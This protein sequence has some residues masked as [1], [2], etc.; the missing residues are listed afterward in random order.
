MKLRILM[1]TLALI[2]I[3]A[4]A[5]AGHHTEEGFFKR[6]TNGDK[7]VSKSEYMKATEKKFK[8][9]DANSDGKV[10]S[11]EY[12]AHKKKWKKHKMKKH[13]HEAKAAKEMK[14]KEKEKEKP[15]TDY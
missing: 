3:N 8:K 11:E 15:S 14:E 13:H 4:T 1:S 2:G 7:M 5:T 6:D 9:M 10:D 12:E